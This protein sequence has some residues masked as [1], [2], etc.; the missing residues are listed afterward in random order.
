MDD[1][2]GNKTLFTKLLNDF[3]RNHSDCCQQLEQM[4]NEKNIGDARRLVHTIH[5]VSGNIGARD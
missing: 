3:N 4:L 2:D 1:H 5:G